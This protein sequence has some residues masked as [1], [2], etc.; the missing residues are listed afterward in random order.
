MKSKK[1]GK[2]FFWMKKASWLAQKEFQGEKL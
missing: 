1:H 2:T